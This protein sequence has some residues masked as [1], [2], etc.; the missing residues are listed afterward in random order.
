MKNI[1]HLLIAST[2]ALA[3]AG[4]IAQPLADGP[5]LTRAEVLAD[6]E[7]YRESGLAQ[8]DDSPIV[9]SFSA[10]Y[11]RAQRRY[12]ELR[13][14]PRYAELVRRNGGPDLD[15][16][17]TATARAPTAGAAMQRPAGE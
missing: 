5:A 8:L 3:A 17:A 7:L 12:R 15:H 10:E 9:T 1:H 14:S 6:L 4:A 2:L 13:A 11:Q 16:Q